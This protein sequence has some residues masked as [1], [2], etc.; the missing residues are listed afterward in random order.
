MERRRQI[1]K[2]I[3]TQSPGPDGQ[4]LRDGKAGSAKAGT[5]AGREALRRALFG[6]VGIKGDGGMS[7]SDGCR[8]T[9]GRQRNTREPET[10]RDRVGV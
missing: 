5:E 8:K 2:V 7:E 3:E 1:D 6:A 10:E 9:R 4:R